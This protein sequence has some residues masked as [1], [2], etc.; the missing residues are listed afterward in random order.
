MPLCEVCNHTP[1]N[2]DLHIEGIVHK[3]NVMAYFLEDDITE[4]KN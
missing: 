4:V 1:W 3:A 2:W